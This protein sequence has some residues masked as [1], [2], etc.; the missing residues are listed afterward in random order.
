MIEVPEGAF[1]WLT[2]ALLAL[3]RAV[4]GPHVAKKRYTLIQVAIARATPGVAE[5]SIW[6][7]DD[8]EEQAKLCARSTWYGKWKHR[9]DIA[10]ALAACEQRLRDWR[11]AETLR[12]EAEALQLR[13]RAIAEGSVDAVQGL[14]KTAMSAKDRADLRTEAS[15]T[16]LALSDEE[17]A[18]RLA[19]LDGGG[20]PIKVS[21]T[22]THAHDYGDKT[23]DELRAILSGQSGEGTGGAEPGA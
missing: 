14:R 15:R 3:L 2:E 11:D 19:R 6:K 17:L 4:R 22:V 7:N 5:D 23:D 21:G 13:R 12:I 10:A 18:L 9:P 20:I 16:L 8:P 1:P